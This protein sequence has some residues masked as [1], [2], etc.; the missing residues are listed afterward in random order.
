MPPALLVVADLPRTSLA[1]GRVLHCIYIARYPIL[2]YKAMPTRKVKLLLSLIY[3]I[4]NFDKN[5]IHLISAT[6]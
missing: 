1:V 3:F 6:A 4:A 2:R 5:F